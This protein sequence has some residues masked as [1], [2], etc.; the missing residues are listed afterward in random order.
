SA[1]PRMTN[2][3]FVRR[4][5]PE[6]IEQDDIRYYREDGYV[7]H[8]EPGPA[9]SLTQEIDRARQ[10]LSEAKARWDSG[11]KTEAIERGLESLATYRR[12]IDALRTV[13][14][15]LCAVGREVEGRVLQKELEF[16]AM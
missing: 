1:I 8:L 12:N 6:T 15:W 3:E 9:V 11:D 5:H 16:L 4:W 10:L 2:E 14:F 7:M 13:S